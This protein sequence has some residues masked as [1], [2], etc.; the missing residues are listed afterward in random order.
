M[1]KLIATTLIIAVIL[2]GCNSAE[3]VTDKNNSSLPSKTTDPALN[4]E[5]KSSSKKTTVR[6]F[7][8]TDSSAWT[9]SFQVI[10]SDKGTILIDPGKYDAELSDYIKS[11]GGVDAIL[12]THG[13]WDKLRGL[14]DAIAANPEAKVYVHELDYPYF[15][16]PERNCSA[17][18]GFKGTTNAQAETL[19]EGNYEIGGYQINVIHMPGHTEGSVLYH[20]PEEN[21]LIGGDT[22]MADQVAGSQHP[23]G[24]EA[25][26]QAS[27][28]KFKQLSFPEDMSIYS[29]HGAKTSYSELL[30][31]NRDLQ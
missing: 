10:N 11:I 8:S 6:T 21:I 3:T 12:I 14:D 27:I 5:S 23:G 26:R 24:N 25:D 29:G 17:E 28:T 16:D 9:A 31:T 15:K 20:F 18:Q 4:S 13:H 30:K 22:I 19:V 7:E 2:T 1:K